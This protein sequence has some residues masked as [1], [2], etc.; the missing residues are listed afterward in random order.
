MKFVDDFSRTKLLENQNTIHNLMNTV[1][2]LQCE[3]S[4]MHDSKDFKD[5]ESVRSGQLSHVPVTQRYFF[6]KMSEEICWA[7]LK[8]CHLVF[9]KS[10]VHRETFFASPAAYPSS[11]YARIPTP[12][13]HHR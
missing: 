7:A 8:V 4:Y 6:T 5:A 13:D 11:S 1:R 2:E 10:S 3:I 12:W 9:G